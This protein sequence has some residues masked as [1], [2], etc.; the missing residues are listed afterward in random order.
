MTDGVGSQLH[1]ILGLYSLARALDVKYVH[2][3]IR[4]VGYQ[5]LMP[6]L[7]G[8]LDPAFTGRYNAFFALPSDDFNLDDCEQVRVHDLD[9]A[10]VERYKAHATAT[11]RPVLIRGHV[12]YSY[13]HRHPAGYYVLR[14]VSPYRDHR[15]AGPVRVCVHL[16]R[17]DNS[18]QGREHEFTRPLTNDYFLRVCGTVVGALQELGVP[19]VV[20][21]HSEVPPRPYAL[22]PGI[23][24]VYFNLDRPSM[25]DPAD[26]ALEDFDVI[27]NLET[28]LNVEP[29][30]CIDDFATAD[31]L[32]LSLS[33][34][35]FVGGLLN[36]H[37]C[38]ICPR[39]GH[40]T[41]PDWLVATRDG[42]VDS[43]QVARRLDGQLRGR[44]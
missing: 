39:G 44:R 3:G 17:G 28:V 25:I 10:A 24:G 5:G 14:T 42:N 21:L 35:G 29:R 1:R 16:R 34:L 11:G 36:P 31:V 41:L 40:V 20:R 13:I 27:P 7:N 6:M 33:S 4:E 18:V 22:H 19:F 12:P 38:V 32:I 2:S 30:E 8:N 9:Q 26:C 43:A 23:S 15:P 37:G